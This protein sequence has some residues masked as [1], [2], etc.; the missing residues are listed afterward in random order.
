[1]GD[2]RRDV[3]SAFIQLLSSRVPGSIDR[4]L[5]VWDWVLG[6]RKF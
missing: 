5:E 2:F 1:M 3:G 4:P 6:S